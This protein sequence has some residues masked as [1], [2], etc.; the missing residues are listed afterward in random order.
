M[1]AASLAGGG[2][3][4]AAEFGPDSTIRL[5]S[6]LPSLFEADSDYIE[7]KTFL[8]DW[9]TTRTVLGSAV[10]PDAVYFD[11]NTIYVTDG[12]STVSIDFDSPLAANEWHTIKL[13]RANVLGTSVLLASVGPVTQVDYATPLP[14][15]VDIIGKNQAAYSDVYAL[16]I[17]GQM[18]Q[19]LYHDT[20]PVTMQGDEN[21]LTI[22]V[23]FELVT[24]G[25]QILVDTLDG[26]TGYRVEIVNQFLG[27]H[28]IRWTVGNGT[29]NTV[30]NSHEVNPLWIFKVGQKVHATVWFETLVGDP[31]P[32]DT[33]FT[34]PYVP[35][36]G[37]LDVGG[38]PAVT[39]GYA[40]LLLHSL[41]FANQ[42]WSDAQITW[43][44]NSGLGRPI[45]EITAI[46]TVATADVDHGYLFDEESGTRNDSFG[47]AHL[48]ENV[49][50]V[51]SP[52]YYNGGFEL[53]EA[54][55][56]GAVNW[57][58]QNSGSF[59]GDIYVTAADWYA[60]INSLRIDWSGSFTRVYPDVLLPYGY[61]Y[62]FSV[63]AKVSDLSGNPQFTW[64]VED[65]GTRNSHV[66]FQSIDWLEYTHQYFPNQ[67]ARIK[68]SLSDTNL[69]G[70]SVHFDNFTAHPD[71]V[72]RSLS[73]YS[74]RLNASSFIGYL[75]DVKIQAGDFPAYYP[76]Y[77]DAIDVDIDNNDGVAENITWAVVDP[78]AP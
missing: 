31:D 7:F 12:E 32:G 57:L 42:K 56:T 74:S 4:G 49:G 60:G 23:L 59:T 76:L 2:F 48:S 21:G 16:N 8:E 67:D 28:I 29:V 61:T 41:F 51:V 20:P 45:D 70:D 75:K 25:N 34:G 69:E 40:N 47:T 35:N 50:Y 63:F 68:L 78:G 9:A 62:D 19:G 10:S 65:S 22:H 71:K 52:D 73:V 37:T 33:T 26:F 1:W 3:D 13:V 66:T 54:S 43:M 14:I 30:I 53:T 18:I 24:Y 36:S 6:R 38:Q 39:G 44:Q 77:T 11:A 58:Q 15:D 17:N 27:T 55:A 46:S 64:R 72:K 5:T